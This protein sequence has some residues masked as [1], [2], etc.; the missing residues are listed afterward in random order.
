MTD[1]PI[2]LLRLIQE[3]APEVRSADVRA[4]LKRAQVEI[5]SPVGVAVSS[6]KRKLAP[7]RSPAEHLPVSASDLIEAG[8]LKPPV[9]LEK[10]YKGTTLRA[11]LRQD[12]KVEFDRTLYD[13]LSVAAEYAAESVSGRRTSLN[14]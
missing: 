4:S 13:S 3:R 12:G 2:A 10:N 9:K 11:T 8:V 7:R 6:S 5:V 14:G 1:A